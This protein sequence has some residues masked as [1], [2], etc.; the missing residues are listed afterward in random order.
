ME[1]ISLK[2]VVFGYQHTPILKNVSFTIN[3]GEFVGVTGPN[4]ASKSTMLRVM[5]G[6]LKPW[7]GTILIHKTNADGKKLKIGYAP[8]QI[9]SFNTGFPS[10]VLEL[11][12]SGQYEKGNWFKRLTRTHH[13]RYK[14]FSIV[15]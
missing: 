1:L 7:K 10:K 8:Q 4:G 15:L 3:R 2:D 9:V 13:Q 11:V 5:L 14:K 6:L 12:K